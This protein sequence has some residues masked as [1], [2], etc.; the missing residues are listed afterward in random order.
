VLSRT[1]LLAVVPLGA[2]KVL[3]VNRIHA[4]SPTRPVISTAVACQFADVRSE[5]A[6]V[7]DSSCLTVV[8]AEELDGCFTT[9]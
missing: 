4:R 9:R 7:Q 1:K 3:A 5:L 2:G 6:I 8:L